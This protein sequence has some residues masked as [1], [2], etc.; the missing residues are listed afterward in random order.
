[1][2]PCYLQHTR[3]GRLQAL[4]VGP[5]RLVHL[6]P[7]LGLPNFRGT[8]CTQQRHGQQYQ[9]C[10]AN[11]YSSSQPEQHKQ[12]HAKV[13]QLLGL[14]VP[15]PLPRLQGAS[16]AQQGFAGSLSG[17]AAGS[18]SAIKH[19]T[20]EQ[21]LQLNLG[22]RHLNPFTEVV[23]MRGPRR[24]MGLRKGRYMRVEQTA[25][26]LLEVQQR[27]SE[28]QQHMA[29][30][31]RRLSEVPEQLSKAPQHLLNMRHHITVPNLLVA[32]AVITALLLVILLMRKTLRQGGTQA[33]PQEDPE[34][35]ARKA[36]SL[37]MQRNRF[38][39]AL[40]GEEDEAPPD[41]PVLVA[42]T[43]ASTSS[44]LNMDQSVTDKDDFAAWDDD[45]QKQWKRFMKGSRSQEIDEEQ[46]W[47]IDREELPPDRQV[48]QDFN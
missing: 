45:T 10:Q 48:Y 6:K 32:A 25:P 1:M 11:I 47:D 19:Q 35:L 23:W 18:L 2:R 16:D 4:A 41:V 42:S 9:G 17:L 33:V 12:G 46:W 24:W 7:V 27:L 3:V 30:V 21:M 40:G 29:E 8:P 44:A 36:A 39:R 34:L 15:Q 5:R 14:G 38:R 37:D 20:G 28:L 13:S 26:W 43:S 31:P 22:S